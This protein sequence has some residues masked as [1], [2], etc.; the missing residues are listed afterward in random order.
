MLGKE[1][2]WR[3]KDQLNIYARHWKAVE[4][5]AVVCIVHGLG[6]H[7]NRY[8]EVAKQF[9]EH[10]FTCLG[11]DRRGHGQSEGE[12]GHS[13]SFEHLL[14]EIKHLLATAKAHYK[15]KPIFL[16]GHSMGGNIVLNYLMQEQ[17][18]IAGAIAT[19]SWIRLSNPPPSLLVQVGKIARRFAPKVSQSNGLNAKDLSRDKEACQ[20]YL[21]DP[22]VHQRITFGL[23]MCM[24]D[25][26]KKIEQFSG[27]LCVPVLIMHGDLDNIT[28]PKATEALAE[29]ID[30]DVELKLWEGAYH[31]IQ[32]EINKE[33]V[34]DYMVDWMEGQLV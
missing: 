14:L 11:N 31:E 33:E 22:L 26:A 13:P 25:A 27:D 17:P 12:R 32:H 20:R 34:I 5:R 1:F 19:G 6:E 7:I 15:D 24:L 8:A 3:T 23:A 29:R 28:D 4:T 18:A 9:N 2:S 10:G 30:S 16:Y 21:D